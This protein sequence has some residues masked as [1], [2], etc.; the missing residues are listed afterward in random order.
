[1]IKV[2]IT[3]GIGSGK[4]YIAEIFEKSC[5]IPV[6]YADKEAKR[7]IQQND[8]VKRQIIEFLGEESYTENGEYNRQ[9]VSKKVFLNDDLREKLNDIVHPAVRLDFQEWSEQHQEGAA[10]VMQEAAIL[11]ETGGYKAFDYTILVTAPE[12]VRF[13]RVLERDPGRSEKSIDQIVK[14]QWPDEK[15]EK[16]ADFV[17]VND[18]KEPVL[19][20]VLEIDKE[21]RA[22]VKK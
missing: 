14:N 1:M 16:L 8:S 6:Y 17:I 19:D 20:R 15:K 2:G 10:Y 3:G 7:I 9:Y 22:K 4:S 12:R 18:G 21:I 13:D 11:F 5:D